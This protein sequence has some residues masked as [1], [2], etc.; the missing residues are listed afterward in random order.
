MTNEHS[1]I[2]SIFGS[3]VKTYRK[4]L[5][6]TQEQLAEKT[7]ITVKYISN[8][9]CSISFPSAPVIVAIA[10]ALGVPEY[11]LFMP[12]DVKSDE[13]EDSYISKTVLRREIQKLTKTL[14]NDLK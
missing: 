8:I 9:E 1:S 11:K 14:L 10:K 3:N 5:K 12:E 4:R 6:M 7:G 13:N 2:V